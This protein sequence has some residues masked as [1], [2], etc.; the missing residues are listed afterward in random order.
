MSSPIGGRSWQRALLRSATRI[1]RSTLRLLDGWECGP[2]G[3]F[4][5]G[6]LLECD[7]LA[8][9]VGDG[10]APSPLIPTAYGRGLS[11]MPKYTNTGSPPM[12]AM[13]YLPWLK[14]VSHSNLVTVPVSLVLRCSWSSQCVRVVGWLQVE[15]RDRGAGVAGCQPCHERDERGFVE[16][17]CT[18]V[19]LAAARHHRLPRRLGRL[20]DH[21]MAWTTAAT[22]PNSSSERV[23]HL[24]QSA[25][26]H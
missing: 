19:G 11:V 13:R 2:G 20:F 15:A 5:V 8:E 23:G 21:V 3:R 16:V 22:Y 9:A 6:D 7:G 17:T 1:A 24:A 12:T 18:H 10:D 26:S 25:P 4:G 14:P